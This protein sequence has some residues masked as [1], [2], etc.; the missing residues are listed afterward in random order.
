MGNRI[1]YND[2]NGILRFEGS[3]PKYREVLGLCPYCGKIALRLTHGIPGR[4]PV[5]LFLWEEI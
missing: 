3:G 5:C 1:N 4:F 2:Q